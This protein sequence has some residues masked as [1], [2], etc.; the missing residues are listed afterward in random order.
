MLTSGLVGVNDQSISMFSDDDIMDNG[1]IM[2]GWMDDRRI[3]GW[4][5]RWMDGWIIDE[6]VWEDGC[7]YRWMD[8]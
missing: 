2:D 3:G 1:W 4:M 5:D 6:W 7:I 8:E